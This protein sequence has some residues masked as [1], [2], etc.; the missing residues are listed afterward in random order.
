MNFSKWI[1]EGDR[2]TRFMVKVAHEDGVAMVTGFNLI[3]CNNADFSAA[4]NS[5]EGRELMISN[6][7]DGNQKHDDIFTLVLIEYADGR[8]DLTWPDCVIQDEFHRLIFNE[9]F[10][11][12]VYEETINDDDEGD[13]A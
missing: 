6:C 2:G 5:D 8:R 9:V 1:C 12:T 10:V 13:E 7:F 4:L 11:C 3:E